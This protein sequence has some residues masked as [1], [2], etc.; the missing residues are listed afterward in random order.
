[1]KPIAFAA[2][3]LNG[4]GNSFPAAQE[5]RKSYATPRLKVVDEAYE[6]SD[7]HI[8]ADIVLTLTLCFLPASKAST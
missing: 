2:R 6:E 4:P 5:L 8:P 1:M 3:L 7:H